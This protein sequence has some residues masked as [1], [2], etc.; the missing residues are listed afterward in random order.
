MIALRLRRSLAAALIVS[1]VGGPAVAADPI[2]VGAEGVVPVSPGNTRSM[3][4]RALAAAIVSAVLEASRRYLAPAVFEVEEERD[5]LRETLRPTAPGF[6]LTYRV[7]GAPIRRPQAE[8][9][10]L[11]E[12]VVRLTATVDGGQLRDFL[13]E[14]GLLADSAEQPS[15]ALRVAPAIGLTA[16]QAA[17]PLA[18]F[19]QFLLRSLESDGFVVVEP[20]LR[21]AGLEQPENALALARSLGAD[22]A[23]DVNVS[24]RRRLAD[25]GVVGGIA[26]VRVRALRA[27]DGAEIARSRFEAP[28]Y[29]RD[30]QEAVVRALEAVGEQVAQNLQLQLERNWQTLAGEDGPVQ[31][32]L[33]LERN[34][35]TLAGEDGPVQLQLINLTSLLQAIAVRDMLAGTLDAE[36]VALVELG[37]GRAAMQ[38]EISLSPGAL[39]DRLATVLFDGF[40]LEPVETGRD[41]VELRVEP[42]PEA[43]D[44][45]DDAA[46]GSP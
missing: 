6:V 1:L 10:D 25:S 9:P 5:A 18:G 45:A 41:R 44:E 33:Q 24:W 34:W 3:R 26:D 29:H 38:V 2:S 20:A 7:D 28:G 30:P 19:E 37:P 13:R 23:L 14:K 40:R 42:I 21:P 15:I 32:Q 27:H 43:T 11:E 17:G 16:A 36:R 35:Q 22:L 39:Q 12:V 46:V 31:L 8:N 4:E